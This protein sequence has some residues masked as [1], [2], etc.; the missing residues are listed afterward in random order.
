MQYYAILLLLAYS[1]IMTDSAVSKT[2]HQQL[3]DTRRVDI[4]PDQIMVACDDPV[5]AG[6]TALQPQDHRVLTRDFFTFGNFGNCEFLE[7]TELN[8]TDIT[9]DA[10][11]A[12]PELRYFYLTDNKIPRL[13][14]AMLNNM[15]PEMWTLSLSNN[16]LFHV[17]NRAFSHLKTLNNLRL[18]HNDLRNLTGN[19]LYGL[20]DLILLDLSYTNVLLIPG[21]F[22]YTPNLIFLKLEGNSF[23]GFTR[24]LWEG[25][26][27]RELDL[28]HANITELERE[29]WDG[30]ELLSKLKLEGNNIKTLRAHIFYGLNSLAFVYLENCNIHYIHARAF[31][32][33]PELW[34]V[35]LGA[36][37]LTKMDG[38]MLGDTDHLRR[39]RIYFDWESMKCKP[40][41]CWIHGKMQSGEVETTL[42]WNPETKCKN[43]N[44]T[45]MDYFVNECKI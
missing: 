2:T 33:T 37:P 24:N 7:L 17:E 3:L 43:L 42:T 14:R 9:E 18:D 20:Q 22:Q 5:W 35:F 31:E 10:F 21:L 40:E 34:Y 23:Q 29:M 45:V 32:G 6:K 1:C 30:L 36:N 41:I 12:V 27:I 11:S 19:T 44:M 8:I 39:V 15:N 28:A 13:T 26:S 25:I 4:T 38:N 16:S